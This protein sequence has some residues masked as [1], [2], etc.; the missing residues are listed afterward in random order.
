MPVPSV[1]NR[2]FST[3][4]ESWQKKIDTAGQQIAAIL[5]L[6][7]SR[8][9]ALETRLQAMER[10][11]VVAEQAWADQSKVCGGQYCAFAVARR[12]LAAR[13]VVWG[14][15]LCSGCSRWCRWSRSWRT[16]C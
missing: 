13:E 9:M 12:V 7:D 6:V 4:S 8:N 1:C 15:E 10:W 2:S 5:S 3:Q 11:R 16:S 14:Q